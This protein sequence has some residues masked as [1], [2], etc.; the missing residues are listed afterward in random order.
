[1]MMQWEP[2]HHLTSGVYTPVILLLV[3]YLHSSAAIMTFSSIS[4]C[5]KMITEVPFQNWWLLGIYTVHKIQ[6]VV[7]FGILHV[8]FLLA[9]GL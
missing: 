8:F 3:S 2:W 4:K 5:T 7:F 9:S 6:Y 1:M